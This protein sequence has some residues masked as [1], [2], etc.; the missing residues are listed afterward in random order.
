MHTNRRDFI[1]GA[2]LAGAG[3]LVGGCALP[4]AQERAPALAGN[5]AWGALLHL[6]FNMWGDWT[7]F[8]KYPQTMAEAEKL[9]GKATFNELGHWNNR[10]AGDYFGTEVPVWNAVTEEMSKEKLNLVIVDLGEAY[11]YPSHPELGANGSWSRDRMNEEVRRLRGLGLEPVPK[12][13]FSTQ[14]DQWLKQYHYMT[15][16]PKY[17]EVVGDLIRDVADVFENPRYIHIGFDEETDRVTLH[18]QMAVVRH[19][20]Q[21]WYDFNRC[22]REVERTGARAITWSDRACYGREE[23]LKN[24]SKDVV[25]MP[26]YYGDDFSD[27]TMAW[28]PEFEKMPTATDMSCYKNLAAHTPLVSDEGFDMIGCTSNW[29]G[30][31]ATDA[32]V[33][34]AKRRLDPKHLLGIVTAPWAMTVERQRDW[35]LN[36]IRLLGAAKRKHYL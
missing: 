35:L 7:P 10:K 15:S 9:M 31:T 27:A 22:V 3:A 21:F 1:K 33:A 16:T 5:F 13:D 2:A 28:K 32:F 20:K 30:T 17:Y 8:E 6:G 11:R 19:G 29:E 34:Y 14:H 23:F 18:R 4:R 25:Q 24:M 36:G 26:W 12:M